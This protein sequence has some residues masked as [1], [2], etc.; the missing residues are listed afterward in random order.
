M[1]VDPEDL[2]IFMESKLEEITLIIDQFYDAPP[3]RI[4]EEIIEGLDY[5]NLIPSLLITNKRRKR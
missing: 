1:A 4:A 2:K 5:D 3:E